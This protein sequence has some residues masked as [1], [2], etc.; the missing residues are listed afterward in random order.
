MRYSLYEETLY[1]KDKPLQERF[2]KPLL[3]HISNMHN[4]S[5][6]RGRLKKNYWK[7]SINPHTS[8]AKSCS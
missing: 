6:V 8:F 3:D 5:T 7:D 2:N 4:K 1:Y